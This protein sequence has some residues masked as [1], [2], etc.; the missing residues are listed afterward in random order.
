MGFFSKVWKGIKTSFV[1]KWVRKAFKRFGK[2]MNKIGIVGQIAMTFLLP[3]VGGMMSKL[4]SGMMKYQGFAKG[5]VQAA[6]KFINVAAN[7]GSKVKGAFKSVTKGVFDTIKNTLGGLGDAMGFDKF[8]HKLGLSKTDNWLDNFKFGGAESTFTKDIQTMFTDVHKNLTS[9]KTGIFSRDTVTSN[10][11]ERQ[12][13]IAQAVDQATRGDLAGVGDVSDY[14]GQVTDITNQ[15]SADF[16]KLVTD[17]N[18]MLDLKPERIDLSLGDAA[19][20]TTTDLSKTLGNLGTDRTSL[21]GDTKGFNFDNI[22]GMDSTVAKYGPSTDIRKFMSSPVMKEMPMKNIADGFKFIDDHSGIPGID[23]APEL[24]V[25][26]ISKW[27]KSDPSFF[28][29]AAVNEEGDLLFS[30]NLDY[31]QN[32]RPEAYRASVDISKYQDFAAK[33]SLLGMPAERGFLGKLKD[34]VTG[35]WDDTT[36]VI[37]DPEKRMSFLNKQGQKFVDRYTGSLASGLANKQIYGDQTPRVTN[38]NIAVPDFSEMSTGTASYVSPMES[39]ATYQSN[40]YNGN[41]YGSP[42]VWYDWQQWASDFRASEPYRQSGLGG[43]Q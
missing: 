13:N 32:V 41:M 21:L 3:G 12:T 4:A 1:G 27:A 19:G 24:N 30:K 31:A 28:E 33:Q 10:L 2:F 34:K 18:K 40:M 43:S 37:T 35:L 9:T 14:R 29:K 7:V 8:T 42:S 11:Y 5:L 38:V 22:K 17:P 6:G 26:D 16:N 20:T 23:F 15:A 36:G 39:A 25:D